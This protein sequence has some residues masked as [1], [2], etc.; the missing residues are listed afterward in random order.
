MQMNTAWNDKM[1]NAFIAINHFGTKKLK[2]AK[3]PK[4]FTT[5]IA[6]PSIM[7]MNASFVP[8]NILILK[9][10]A[11]NARKRAPSKKETNNLNAIDV[12]RKHNLDAIFT[13]NN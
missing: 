3:S 2:N 11:F 7:K 12:T 8:L 6:C 9:Q 1:T 10:L 13:T 5:N 4:I